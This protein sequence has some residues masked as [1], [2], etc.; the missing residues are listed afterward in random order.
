MS[1]LKFKFKKYK[2]KSERKNLIKNRTRTLSR[3]APRDMSTAYKSVMKK[4][5][6][7]EDIDTSFGGGLLTEM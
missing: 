7:R 5:N 6:T 1:D 4:K 2:N 3:A